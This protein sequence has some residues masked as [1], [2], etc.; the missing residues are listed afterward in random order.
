M[1]A[2]SISGRSSLHGWGVRYPSSPS[3]PNPVGVRSTDFDAASVSNDVGLEEEIQL[4][5]DELKALE[6][7]RDRAVSIVERN[8]KRSRRLLTRVQSLYDS[9]YKAMRS[10]DEANARTLLQEKATVSIALT[11]AESRVEANSMLAAKLDRIIGVRQTKLV[12]LYSA[13]K[14][15]GSQAV[16][17]ASSDGGLTHENPLSMSDIP[18]SPHEN[19]LTPDIGSEDTYGKL[20]DEASRMEPRGPDEL[21]YDNRM[22]MGLPQSEQQ[23]PSEE[24]LEV[25]FLNLERKTLE[26]M[27]E[28]SGDNDGPKR[29]SKGKQ[30]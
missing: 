16:A 20:D 18:S 7:E 17:S 23:F 24:D 12:R 26:R 4:L 1:R 27:L 15:T 14:A 19:S 9:A 11:K 25:A 5:E 30:R 6:E 28:R 13:M 8:S 22:G 2:P 10:G 3:Y 29:S 21:R